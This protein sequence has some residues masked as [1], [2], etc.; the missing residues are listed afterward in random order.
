MIIK[1]SPER[2]HETIS[3]ETNGKDRITINGESFDFQSLNEGD[4][5][6]LEDIPSPYFRNH[7][8]RIN[9]EIVLTLALPH[10]P[11]PEIWQAF[12]EE[13][14]VT[15]EGL[16]DIPINSF[17]QIIEE[18]VPPGDLFL[19]GAVMTKK[20]HHRWHQEPIEEITYI[21]KVELDVDP[22]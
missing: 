1:L 18:E 3:L 22:K 19:S 17:T 21:E 8:T 11:N 10:G 13:I 6:K 4:M 14:K 15:K 20:I 5:V 7:V 16:V 2:S 12:P 9:G